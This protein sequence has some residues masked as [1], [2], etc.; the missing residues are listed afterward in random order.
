[1][2]RGPPHRVAAASAVPVAR[3]ADG[4]TLVL[5]PE[6]KGNQ[7]VGIALVAAHFV[8]MVTQ[9]IWIQLM[10]AVILLGLTFLVGAAAMVTSRQVAKRREL[11]IAKANERAAAAN[12]AARRLCSR[13][14]S[15]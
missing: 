1:M 11:D 9:M 7:A 8:L 14:N 6:V 5:V 12:E 15:V 3:G 10:A 13:R 4:R 2:L